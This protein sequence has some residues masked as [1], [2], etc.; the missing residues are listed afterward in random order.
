VGCNRLGV[1]CVR[2]HAW[3]GFDLV[4]FGVRLGGHAWGLCG[5]LMVH[6]REVT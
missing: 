2:M 6:G 3:W 1:L 4:M 5:L